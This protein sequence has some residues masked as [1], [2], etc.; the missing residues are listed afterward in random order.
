MLQDWLLLL[1]SLGYLSLLFAIAWQGDRRA[2][3]WR[4]GAREP[5]IYA[6]ALAI[7]CTSWTFFGSVGRAATNGA[8]F[9]L[10]YVGPVLVI[11]L[12]YPF[13]RKMALVA[14]AQNV[15]SIADFIGAR[16]GKSRAVA[17]LVAIVAMIGVL[18]YI[19]LQLQAVSQSFETLAGAAFAPGAYMPDT[20]LFVALT[21]AVFAIL[22]GVRHVQASERHDGMILAIAF[23]SLVKLAAFLAAG[24][25]VVFELYD[26]P[27]DL[28]ARAV[29]SP[30]VAGAYEAGG[31]QLSW[32]TLTL[33]AA[34]AFVCLPRQFH[35]A[36]V[37]NA[38][39][40][41][42]RTATW[43]FPLY[44][45]AINLFVP[46][47]AAAGMLVLG[48]GAK[49]DQ[50]VLTLPMSADRL[51]LSLAVYIGGLSAAT[52]MVIVASVAISTMVS[53]EL[54]VP[55]MLR[56]M[57]ERPAMAGALGRR[58]LLVR[59][60]SIF[61]ALLLAYAY[62]ALL[63]GR[64]P[65]V[66]IGLVSFCAVAQFAPAV[67]G[68]L[69]WRRAHRHGAFL[70]VLGGAL[71]WAY[72][73]LLPTFTGAPAIAPAGLPIDAFS[74]NALLSLGVNVALFVAGSLLAKPEAR[75]LAQAEAFVSG[76][77]A[78]DVAAEPPAPPRVWAEL[79][80]LAERFLGEAAA[81]SAFAKA[82][83]ASRPTELAAF[84]ERL[85]SGAIGA[86][87]ARIVVAATLRPRLAAIRPAGGVLEQAYEAILYNR[88]LLRSTIDSVGL[89]LAVFD[90]ERRLAVWN[91][92]FLDLLG[93]AEGAVDVGAPIAE[94][95]AACRARIDL[96][97]AL[98]G[99]A[100][101]TREARRDDGAVL[102]LR[103]SPMPNGGLVLVCAD[104]TERVR[105]AERLAESEQRIRVYTDNVPALMSYVDRQ[106]RYRFT[107]R[108]Y[109]EALGLSREAAQRLTIREALGE[110]RYRRLKPYIDGAF[111]GEEQRFEIEFP[112]RS[113]AFALAQGLYLPH[114]DEQGRVIGFFSLYQDITEQRRAER[115]LLE[116]KLE[117]E[118]R[119][120][121]RT[122]DLVRLNEELKHARDAAD[123]ANLG[124]TR[125]LAA[126]SHDLSQPLH[127]ARLFV[128]TLADQAG[129][130]ARLVERIDHALSTV[131]EMLRALLEISRL[132]AGALTPDPRPFALDEMLEGLIA[133][134]QP[135]A[136]RRTLR[137]RAVPTSAVAVSDP[138]L[139]R[140]VLQNFLSNAIRY[141]ERGGVL[142]GCRRRG[143]RVAVEVWDTG[144]GIPEDKLGEAFQEFRRFAET[145]AEGFPGVGL[146]LAI[147]QR[148]ARVLGHELEV[149]SRPGRGSV[150]AIVL[151]RGTAA[152]R[153]PAPAPAPER[154]RNLL[155]GR[156]VLCLDDDREVLEA[157]RTLL[158]GWG[159]QVVAAADAAAACAAVAQLGRAPDLLLLDYHLAGG[160]NGFAALDALHAG[161]ASGAPA[162]LVTANHT[163][164][165]RAAAQA[166][167]VPLVAKPAKPAAL[168]ALMSQ[169]IAERERRRAAAAE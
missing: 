119:V 97:P 88:D 60:L 108:P 25:F 115:A 116:A 147:V 53:N 44:L 136:E 58:L 163:E 57:T 142:I 93:L 139:L 59:R 146:G 62:Y 76:A 55:A 77:A 149:R 160:E 70:G 168:R 129:P 90:A 73:M 54:I 159:C 134:F 84:V 120:E 45:L 126:A 27:S 21:M 140:R 39:P 72:T 135:M 101:A 148:I 50:F 46:A 30:L 1:A 105:A 16:Y 35:V 75:D 128:A 150:F 165:V 41:N 42:L 124:K 2:G 71:V 111:A 61:A 122:R 10:I 137:L 117:L 89:G 166:R 28:F 81:A 26:G 144:P 96:A 100:E 8:D 131:E 118:R 38:N 24:A 48:Q 4:D 20:A 154:P 78:A 51:W 133:S 145:D 65:L 23:E 17:A 15:T 31:P 68:G 138:A 104:V 52:S 103:T 112:T 106:E 9:V 153:T 22:F 19:A 87:S 123:A 161:P 158:Q 91:R 121:E 86:A 113:G 5:V 94:V 143:D 11:T 156:V 164:A 102:E 56:G 18:P 151:P 83:P 32:F 107:N 132:D 109:E 162:V 167:G 13:M 82:P 49:P 155:A 36:M 98:D 43:L 3:A 6:L 34:C 7:Y 85:L 12:G 80:A 157:M 79:R 169:L 99:A 127:A 110:E 125:F 95:V 130:Q 66:S 63:G 141:T 14:R 69:Y 64:Y 152:A 114:R 67:V 47:I 40:A 74:A 33:V 92:R 29:E 37:A